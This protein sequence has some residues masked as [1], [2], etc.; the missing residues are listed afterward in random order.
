MSAGVHLWF[1]MR[2]KTW[3]SQIFMDYL[4]NLG[5]YCRLGMADFAFLS[6]WGDLHK[7]RELIRR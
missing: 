6:S 3:V 4:I 7:D 5:F 2:L 1:H